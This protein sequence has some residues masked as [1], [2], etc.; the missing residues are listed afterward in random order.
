MDHHTGDNWLIHA[1]NHTPKQKLVAKPGIV[2]QIIFSQECKFE[3]QKVHC[4][5]FN[6]LFKKDI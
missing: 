4:S 3:V 2:L 6:P 1:T 5:M